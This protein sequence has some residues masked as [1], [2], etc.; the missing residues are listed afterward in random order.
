MSC[1]P[2]I[3]SVRSAWL[4]M[5]LMNPRWCTSVKMEPLLVAR[6][7]PKSRS[8]TDPSSLLDNITTYFVGRKWWYVWYLQSMKH[9][10]R[11]ICYNSC[12]HETHWCKYYLNR[13]FMYQNIKLAK[14]RQEYFTICLIGK[15]RSTTGCSFSYRAM[16]PHIGLGPPFP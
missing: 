3:D 12:K 14:L 5:S 1:K 13:A 16:V 4:L 11:P 15:P 2:V 8:V 10:Y 7:Q 6:A 9:T